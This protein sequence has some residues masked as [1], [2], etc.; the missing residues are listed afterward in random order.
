MDRVMKPAL[1]AKAGI[2]FY[3]LIDIANGLTVT[4]YQIDP[5]DGVYQPTGTFAG[6]DVIRLEEPWPIEIP[7]R[8]IR[9]RNL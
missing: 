1:D 4:T 2:P 3:W 7:V 5:E 6:E 8:A 9:P